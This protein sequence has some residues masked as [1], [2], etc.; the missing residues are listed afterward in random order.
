MGRFLTRRA[1][2][3]HYARRVPP[4]FAELDR[5][6]IVKQ[7]T[8][9][10]VAD[11]PRGLKA[12]AVA[13]QINAETEAYWRGLLDGQSAEASRRYEAARKRARAMGFDYA[14]AAEVAARP[15][16]EFMAR[17]ERVMQARPEAEESTA[18]AVLGGEAPPEVRISS[19]FDTYEKLERGSLGDMSEDQIRKW[20][21]PKRR[22]VANLLEVLG[23]KALSK[24]SR[25]DALDFRAWWQDRVLE[26][27]IAIETA[28]KDI[29]HLNKMFRTIDRRH[30]LSLGP[31]FGEMRIEGGSGGQRAAYETEFLQD[32]ILADGALDELN[33]EARRVIYL[34]IETGLRPSEAVNLTAQTIILKGPVPHVKVRAD[35][36][37]LKTADSM[38]DI[39]LV[40][41]SL[42]ALRAQPEGFPRYRDNAATLSATINKFLDAHKLRPTDNHTLYSLRHSFEDRL[43]AVEP[44][45]KLIAV[46]MGHKYARPKYGS[47]PSLEQKQKWLQLI[48]LKPPSRV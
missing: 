33:A 21:N 2:F 4:P 23:D 8:K 43:T 36:R 6:G 25:T 12:S 27:G 17:L 22:A 34:M 47:G 11:D 18:A 37:R 10:R 14:Q 46:L 42:A 9:V 1:G 13:E 45:D 39:P 29:G 35:E 41:V 3:W 16:D 40:G 32:R 44:Q 5:R 19:L 26:E 24:I 15:L 38:R 28:N 20:R 48:A 30:Q 7:S 31:I